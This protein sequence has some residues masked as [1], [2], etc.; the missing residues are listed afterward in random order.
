MFEACRQIVFQQNG[1]FLND[2]KQSKGYVC[3]YVVRRQ[4]FKLHQK[5]HDNISLFS[6]FLPKITNKLVEVGN[7][8]FTAH[9]ELTDNFSGSD[10]VLAESFTRI[11]KINMNIKQSTP[12]AIET[13]QEFSDLYRH[14]SEIWQTKEVFPDKRNDITSCLFS[15]R[16]PYSDTDR[17][18]HITH[19]MYSKYYMDCATNAIK[20]G[21]YRHFVDDICWYPTLEVDIEYLGDAA[22]GE[23]IDI[24]TW[25]GENALHLYFETKRHGKVI[26]KAVFVMGREKSRKN[27]H[28]KM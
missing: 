18:Q 19:V 14:P 15:I 2:I 1:F 20:T 6:H 17:L 7:S 21:F 5:L 27:R 12:L 16:V 11:V 13:K 10:E 25:Q 23:V 3:A 26:N 28:S 8:S 24:L 9:N 22:A 4:R